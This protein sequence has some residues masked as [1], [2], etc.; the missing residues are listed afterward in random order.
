MYAASS[1][2]VASAA[3]LLSTGASFTA[4]TTRAKSSLLEPASL[5]VTVRVMVTEPDWLAAGTSRS[6]RSAPVPSR[7]KFPLGTRDVSDEVS[8]TATLPVGV[9]TSPRV[10]SMWPMGA[11]SSVVWGRMAE[12]VGRSFTGLTVST[13]LSE[14]VPPQPSSTVTVIVVEPF[15]SPAGTRLSVRLAPD[16]PKT[17]FAAGTKAG[18]D[19]LATILTA[20]GEV[21]RSSTVKPI[22]PSGASSS[23]V[24]SEMLE[25]VGRSLTELTVSRNVSLAVAAPS[26]T[27]I[28]IVAVPNLSAT[29]VTV[30]V[31]LAP[32]PA[33]T[34]L[35]TGTSAGLDDA[36]VSVKASA[37]VSTSPTL[38]ASAAVAASSSIVRLPTSEIVGASFTAATDNTKVDR[39]VAAPS[40]TVTVMIAVPKR[41]GAGVSEIVRP[42]PAPP[43]TMFAS[44]TKVWSDDVALT[45]RLPAGDSTSATRK[46]TAFSGV[47]SAI[48]LFVRPET[49]GASLI[50]LTTST[51]VSVAVPPAPS[52]TVRVIVAV[53]DW[54]AAGVTVSVRLPPL[55]AKT[56]LPAGTSI[57][58]DEL[59]TTPNAPSAVS[60]SPIAKLIGPSR[61]S[62]SVLRSPRCAIVGRSFT[63]VTV[64][65]KISVTRPPEPSSA[66]SVIVVVPN[67]SASGKIETVRLAPL[68]V[69]VIL[70]SGTNARFDEVA[71]TFRLLVST[72]PTVNGR[73]P[74]DESS[75][76]ARLATSEIVGRS[77][78]AS[79]STL[80]WTGGVEPPEVSRAV[81]VK[82]AM[83]APLALP[84][85]VQ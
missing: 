56:I 37:A 38:N 47:S 43:A 69:S 73:L 11:S 10:K 18:L 3:M 83:A 27:V 15:W 52:S 76:I 32:L 53:P 59:P 67:W 81:M 22:G 12:I 5:S 39:L 61:T 82:A 9:S 1:E 62:S 33:K 23:I 45:V 48:A 74:V 78:I 71:V 44:G 64:S 4:L 16:P 80:T 35:P 49:V 29:G 75:A 21:S 19:E 34:I 51:K 13:K 31:R 72:S 84:A 57:V 41:L 25:I 55:P 20:P 77:L 8:V 85:G 63:G 40:L 2:I 6:D 54:F 30:T 58:F 26:P 24:L 68:P 7:V 42:S 70:P 50:G 17:M 28:V 60:R 65:R 46:P 14:A 36:P 66:V 79:T